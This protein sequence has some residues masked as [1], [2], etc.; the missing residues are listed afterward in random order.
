MVASPGA[1]AAGWR[2]VFA[3]V[4]V[5]VSVGV[6]VGVI[7]AV[8]VVIL[9]ATGFETLVLLSEVCDLGF[10]TA[11]VGSNVFSIGDS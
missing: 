9:V 5:G 11:D 4:V 8:G 1:G 2:I 10:F 3:G 6:D 7:V